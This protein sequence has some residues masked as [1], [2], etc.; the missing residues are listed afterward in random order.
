MEEAK[1]R[2]THYLA[3]ERRE[4]RRNRIEMRRNRIKTAFVLMLL[5]VTA[6]SSM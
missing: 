6:F 2:Y 1:A 3:G 5:M 4:M